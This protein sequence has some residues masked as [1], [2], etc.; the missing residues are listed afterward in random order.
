MSEQI[1]T[2]QRRAADVKSGAWRLTLRARAQR[3]LQLAELTQLDPAAK[4]RAME[5][6]SKA[7]TLT[8][9]PQNFV[10]AW[11]GSQV[12]EAWMYLRLAEESFLQAAIQAADVRANAHAALSHARG[13]LPDGDERVTALTHSIADGGADPHLAQIADI[14]AHTLKVTV[15]SH[16]ISDEQHR[17]QREFR[18]RLRSITAGLFLMAVVVAIAA[19]LATIPPN[20]IP[21]PAGASHQGHVVVAALLLGALGALFSAVPSLAQAPTNT[22]TFNPIVEQALLKVV[23]GSWSALV[24]LA[25]VAAGIQTSEGDT[26]SPAGFAM[27][28]ALFGAMQEALTRFADHKAAETKPMT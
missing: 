22:T 4:A 8:D 6:L 9:D 17:A 25:A 28:C 23:V 26:A 18:N 5:H 7:E 19:S 1:P 2:S 16:E 12:E 11:T 3:L 10:E 15:A 13:R 14:K 24:G 27:M 21:A 20:W